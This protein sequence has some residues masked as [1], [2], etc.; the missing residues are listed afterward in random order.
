MEGFELLAPGLRLRGT[1]GEP[2]RFLARTPP[3]EAFP[4]GLENRTQ[5]FHTSCRLRWCLQA[6][7]SPTKPTSRR[8]VAVAATHRRRRTAVGAPPLLHRRAIV[9]LKHFDM[10]RRCAADAAAGHHHCCGQLAVAAQLRRLATVASSRDAAAT[11]CCRLE[12]QP[13]LSLPGR[14]DRHAALPR[15]PRPA[16]PPTAAAL[17]RSARDRCG[18]AADQQLQRSVHVCSL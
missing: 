1:R 17:T 11:S 4:S 12:Q 6:G 15:P 9:I 14:Q 13:P 3:V 18:P 7:E 16:K 10:S 5:A 8:H 2:G